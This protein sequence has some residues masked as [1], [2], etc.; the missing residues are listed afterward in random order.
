MTKIL[1]G[2]SVSKHGKPRKLIFM[3]HGYGDNAANFMNLAHSIDQENWQAQYV[4]LNAPCFIPGN[5]MGYQWFDLYPNGVY[6]TEAGP[7]EFEQIISEVNDSV[8]KIINTIEN[9]CRALEL[10]FEDCIVMGFSQG[11]KRTLEVDNHLKKKISGLA[12]L[13][14]HIMNEK[15]INNPILKNIPIFISHGQNDEVISISSYYKAKKYLK[16]NK[17][18]VE[19]YILNKDGHNIS[20]ET[21]DLLQN[22]IKKVL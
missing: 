14:G 15:P 4:S 7:N 16:N 9:Y 6:I 5:P 13:S 1:N 2:T 10:T 20:Q 12:I 8:I 22:F 17:C 3:L 21:I 18:V 19:S 11:G